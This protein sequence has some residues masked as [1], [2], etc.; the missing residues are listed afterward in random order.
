MKGSNFISFATLLL[1]AL[2]VWDFPLRAQQELRLGQHR[3]VPEQNVAQG[4]RGASRRHSLPLGAVVNGRHNV[5]VQFAKP[6]E[7][8][9]RALLES[10]GVTLGDYLGG[11][12]Y[13]ATVKEGFSPSAVQRARLTSVVPIRGEWKMAPAIEN[14]EIP[15]YAKAGVDAARVRL[16]HF[17]NVTTAWVARELSKIGIKNVEAMPRFSL[18]V[19]DLPKSK[20][21]EVASLPWVASLTL[22]PA[23]QEVFNAQGRVMGKGNLLALSGSQGGR[24]LTG[25]GVRVGVWDGNVEPHFDYAARLHQEEFEF[26]VKETQGHGMHVAGSI[27][28]AGLLNPKM[29]GVAPGAQI[30]TYNFNRQSNGLNEQMEMVQALEKYGVYL[31]SHSYGPLL[32]QLCPY[33]GEAGYNFLTNDYLIDLLTT[34]EPTITQVYAA[35]ND[36]GYCNRQYGSVLR[37][38]KNAIYVGALDAEGRMTN[39]SS[40]GPQD[41]GRVVPT[42]SIKGDSVRSTLPGDRYGSMSGTSMATPLVSGHLA[43][44]TERYHQLHA[45]RQPEAALLRALIIASADDVNA[46]GPDYSYGY[47]VLNADAA[48][49]ALEKGQYRRGELRQGNAPA[50]YSVPVPQ[51]TTR[52]WVALAWTD[53][54]SSAVRPYGDPVLINDLNL[55]VENG[56]V[57]YLPWVLDQENLGADPV[58]KED[59]INNAELVSVD[60]PRGELIITISPKQVA[61]KRQSF[62]VVW[63]FDTNEPR[64]TYP[65]GGEFFEPGDTLIIQASNMQ[66]PIRAELSYDNGKTYKLLAQFRGNYGRVTLPN[67]ATFTAE[68]LVRLIDARGNVVQSPRSF[69]IMAAPSNVHIEKVE[70]DAANVLLAWEPVEGAKEYEV[71]YTTDAK[72]QYELIATTKSYKFLVP[73]KYLTA[74]GRYA[75]T[76]KAVAENGAKS[77]RSVAVVT[78]EVA[79]RN[80]K[81]VAIPFTEEF[82]V[83]PS[84][85]VFVESGEYMITTY[86][87]TPAN[88]DPS[89]GAHVLLVEKAVGPADDT[90]DESDPFATQKSYTRIGLRHLNLSGESGKVFIEASGVLVRGDEDALPQLRLEVDGV[91]IKA[92]TGEEAFD[93][94][95][96]RQYWVWELTDYKAKPVEVAL[97]TVSKNTNYGLL[98]LYIKVRRE[99]SQPDLELMNFAGINRIGAFEKRT[100]VK[101]YLRN[102]S[103]IHIPSAPIYAFANGRPIGS[104]IVEDI[105]PFETREVVYALDLSTTKPDGELLEIEV[106]VD[107]EGDIDKANNVKKGSLYNVGEKYPMKRGRYVDGYYSGKTD[108][109]VVKGSKVITDDG[110]CA[111]G[112][113]GKRDELLLLKPSNPDKVLA[114]TVL[115]ASL[116]GEQDELYINTPMG[117]SSLTMNRTRNL[118]VIQ[119]ELVHPITLLSTA[120]DGGIVLA[121]RAANDGRG[122]GWELRATE[123]DRAN[124][125]TLETVSITPIP[126][127]EKMEVKATVKNVSAERQTDIAIT[128]AQG[129]QTHMVKLVATEFIQSLAPNE[130]LEYT[131]EYQPTVAIP[132]YDSLRVFIDGYD[133]EFSDNISRHLVLNDR[134]C[135]APQLSAGNE[136]MLNVTL[137]DKVATVWRHTDRAPINTY[138]TLVAYRNAKSSTLQVGLDGVTDGLALGVWVDWNDDKQLGDAAS[139]EF[140]AVEVSA[141]DEIATIPLVVPAD[142]SAGVKRMRVLLAE[143]ESLAA[144]GTTVLPRSDGSDFIVLL[145]DTDFPFAGDLALASLVTTRVGM[146]LKT[147]EEVKVVIENPSDTHVETLQVG[148][149]VDNG[150]PVIETVTCDLPPYKGK[151]EYTFRNKANLAS[152][153][154][155]TI[156]AWI[157]SSNSSLANDTLSL[158]V[159]SL[160]PDATGV[161]Y[162]LHFGGDSTR[163][164]MLIFSDLVE[165][166]SGSSFCF[167]FMLR[168]DHAQFAPIC[169]AKDF[170]MLAC[171]EG[172]GF[173]EN[174]VL[175]AY[176]GAKTIY[177]SP[178]GTLRPGSWQHIAVDQT[179]ADPVR[180]RLFV[181]GEMVYLASVGEEGRSSMQNFKA[182]YLFKGSIDNLRFWKDYIDLDIARKLAYTNTES[183][184]TAIKGE[185]IAE[186][187]M[188]EGPSNAALYAGKHYA[189]VES[190]RTAAGDNSIWQSKRDI[191]GGIQF[192]NQVG[193]IDTLARKMYRVTLTADSDQS[194]VIGSARSNFATGRVLYDGVEVTERTHF[195]F[196]AG[197]VTLY[198]L[199]VDYYGRNLFDTV[200]IT[201]VKEPSAACELLTLNASAI[202]NPTLG[203]DVNLQPVPA[204]IAID[205][206]AAYNGENFTFSFTLS[207]GATAYINGQLLES[208][209]KVNL[210]V[211]R[212]LRVL[213]ANKRTD[214]LYTIAL[215]KKN[216]IQWPLTQRQMFYGD[217]LTGLPTA[218][219]AG[220]PVA[221]S[222]DSQNVI[223]YT[224]T[225]FRAVGV[226]TATLIAQQPGGKHYAAAESVRHVVEVLPRQATIAPRDMEIAGGALPSEIELF[227]A[228]LL[229]SDDTLFSPLPRY[230]IIKDGAAWIPASGGLAPG[231]YIIKPESP[232]P[233]RAE[234]YL[235]TPLE[236]KLTVRASNAVTLSLAVLD[237]SS[238]AVEGAAITIDG[239][240]RGLSGTTPLKVDLLPGRYGYSVVRDGYVAVRD[241]VVVTDAPLTLK[242]VLAKRD[243]EIVYSVDGHGTLEG[244]DTQTVARG[245]DGTPVTAVPDD[246][247]VFDGWDDGE[248]RA[249]RVERNVQNAVH[250]TARFS[251]LTHII[252]YAATIGGTI[253]GNATQHVAH[254]QNS[255]SVT[256]TPD[257][258]C[259]F[260]GWGDGKKDAAR[261][262]E[263][264]VAPASYTAIFTKKVNLPYTQ[265]FETSNALPAFMYY[266]EARR[267]GAAWHVTADAVRGQALDGRFLAIQNPE[268][269]SSNFGVEVYT[270]KFTLANVEGDITLEFD[271]IF[272]GVMRTSVEVCYSVDGSRFKRLWK[273]TNDPNRKR[274]HFSKKIDNSLFAGKSTLQLSFYYY[275]PSNEIVCIDNLSVTPSNVAGEVQL[276]YYATEGGKVNGSTYVNAKTTVGTDGAEVTAVHDAGWSFSQWSDGLSE[277]TRRDSRATTVEALFVPASA[278]VSLYSLSY[279]ANSNGMIAGVRTQT[280]LK[281]GEQGT[282]VTAIPN[283]E[284][285]HFVQWSDGRTDNPRVDVV[286]SQD[287]NVTATFSD[288]FTLAY[289]VEPAG[290]AE[291]EGEAKQEVVPGADAKPVTA[292]PKAGYHFVK[293]SDGVLTPERTDVGVQA[294]AT[295]TATFAKEYTLVYSAGKGGIVEGATQQ[296]VQPGAAGSAVVAKPFAGYTFKGWSDGVETA[297]RTDKG[298]KE[299]RVTATFEPIMVTVAYTAAEGGVLEGESANQ[300]VPYGTNSQPVYAK[301][302]EG[303]HFVKWSDGRKDNPRY[304]RTL[305]ADVSAEAIFSKTFTLTYTVAA[306]GT[307]EG[308]S[309]QTVAYGADAQ[310]VTAVPEANYHFV[311]WSDGVKEN[312]RTDRAV[313]RD[314]AVEAHFSNL[315]AITYIAEDGGIIEGTA[316]QV[317]EVAADASAVEAKPLPGYEFKGWSD[318]SDQAVRQEKGVSADAT[319][320]A[321]FEPK[322]YTLKV[323]VTNGGFMKGVPGIPNDF[324]F[325]FAEPE[326]AAYEVEHGALSQPVNFKFAPGVTFDEWEDGSTELPRFFTLDDDRTVKATVKVPT[327]DLYVNHNGVPE[328]TCVIFNSFS[329]KPYKD[330]QEVELGACVSVNYV[331]SRIPRGEQLFIETEG[332]RQLNF[333]FPNLPNAT[334]YQI[335]DGSKPARISVSIRRPSFTVTY[336]ATAGGLLLGNAKQE[337]LVGGS[338]TPVESI[339]LPGYHFVGW[340]DGKVNPRRVDLITDSPVEVTAQFEKVAYTVLFVANGGSGTMPSQ[341]MT[342]GEPQALTLNAFTRLY[343]SFKGWA[344]SPNAKEPFYSDG[345]VVKNLTLD[346]GAQL[347]LY[348]LWDVPQYALTFDVAAGSEGRGTLVATVG[349]ASVE[350]GKKWDAGTK[351]RLEAKPNEGFEVEGWQ[352]VSVTPN[353]ISTSSFILETNTEITVSFKAKPPEEKK[354]GVESHLLSAVEALPNPFATSVTLTNA[355]NI[356]R[357]SLLTVAGCEVMRVMHNGAERLHINTETLPAGI[358]LLRCED[359]QGA[360]RTLRVVKM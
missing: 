283:V 352:G 167:D 169:Q 147:D 270:P 284:G 182:M 254:K 292:K 84:P 328:A 325:A 126:N 79:Q 13:F 178:S 105:K 212:V 196:S 113:A 161:D 204:T 319:Y 134:Y 166:L 339:A 289:L 297:G 327:V 76:V 164:E 98:L 67:D 342:Y 123:I 21:H 114:I 290:S 173:P 159:H 195:D 238:A 229:P 258:D 26:S 201:V 281:S 124:T 131:F 203:A 22:A 184:S 152:H 58:R 59:N 100:L 218:S 303:F 43:L 295:L 347:R 312:P 215:S 17:P 323:D 141:G 348:A 57:S 50:S 207:E 136:R 285:F 216:T 272:S 200:I 5:L 225:S 251:Q 8:A 18:L 109:L 193:A 322:K 148:Y 255:T 257:A 332:L 220:L 47:G 99:T 120:D 223:T 83:V 35:G 7:A 3:F 56:G 241:T 142:A 271:Y 34:L 234:N 46:P 65:I 266:K 93:A 317:V 12:A 179:L 222:S 94:T 331:P 115:R 244:Y 316:E 176:A 300:S 288:R 10:Q 286:E 145:E 20:L 219:D 95:N 53:T 111:L 85:D 307:L 231:E 87:E 27:A 73:Q 177:L 163:N 360:Y 158:T 335:I 172:S 206:P 139:G 137:F 71:L 337:V 217:S 74:Q 235:V 121:F 357:V 117:T 149:S 346:N 243:I 242:V 155:H 68:A 191:I 313:V 305:I 41:D 55:S 250:A 110:G 349:D 72:A 310:L 302:N 181:D 320:T 188:N 51:G 60:N 185:L 2:L 130:S 82:R 135:A 62:Y 54:V 261:I 209:A 187:S 199:V 359:T 33:V 230:A 118:A 358:Y 213:A 1:A 138:D 38:A 275:G 97:R 170:V 157:A 224:G 66:S 144:C 247:Y 30:Y 268:D 69:T 42:I 4:T 194:N 24:G 340:S 208:P 265:R 355:S 232:E 143:K 324:A 227:Y 334:T 160:A 236:G 333:K 205:A 128:I 197:A 211:P 354:T 52:A 14:W 102:H 49:S 280:A 287:I 36:Q 77:P 309:M 264:V 273:L 64:I 104:T 174:S 338:S 233:Y 226:G 301:A 122:G 32:Q 353:N 189:I 29:R 106:R 175:F 228:E 278:G 237:A 277:A 112:Y 260:V 269:W 198:G 23:P 119:G 321:H 92:V 9:Q 306:G 6:L 341:S 190:G 240:L 256:A 259:D 210:A 16:L 15:S 165:G 293:W 101:S 314:I 336:T 19:I 343:A 39:F 350:S 252:T 125:L 318:G 262:D 221:F 78:T 151:A 37:R 246:G 214:A 91:P 28:G 326:Q 156:A 267:L 133:T 274:T 31:S 249:C 168:L 356:N 248:L 282:P 192:E 202:D 96:E 180:P 140:F 129:F 279:A 154:K 107:A 90:W 299:L 40:W 351:V 11:N 132:T 45:G 81:S 296:Q 70:K 183:L 108:E 315:Y 329:G 171:A 294:S 61:S 116:Q 276:N 308:E 304:E 89:P 25:E 63:H 291:I 344:Y 186:F 311:K 103:S 127:T 263:V 86:E 150:A 153:G 88:L 44:M 239:A 245:E 162:Y 75:F 80:A 330:L 345:E 253:N 298:E 48:L 146:P